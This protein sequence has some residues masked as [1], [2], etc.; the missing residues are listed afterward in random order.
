VWED[1]YIIGWWE[2]C[3]KLCEKT[4]KQKVAGLP[5]E[6]KKRKIPEGNWTCDTGTLSLLFDGLAMV[7]FSY[8]AKKYRHWNDTA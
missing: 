7:F 4:N 6:K 1:G 3:K 5:E 2:L 8:C